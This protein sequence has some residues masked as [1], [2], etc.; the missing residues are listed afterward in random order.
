MELA[1]PSSTRLCVWGGAGTALLRLYGPP[2]NQGPSQAAGEG[3][4]QIRDGWGH[5]GGSQAGKAAISQHSVKRGAQRP[6]PPVTPLT[7]TTTMR[8]SKLPHPHLKAPHTPH[9][10]T[11]TAP[12][13]Q[14]RPRPKPTIPIHTHTRS[15]SPAAGGDV[16][17]GAAG[18]TC[19]ALRHLCDQAE[20]RGGACACAFR[21]CFR[22]VIVP[23]KR[24][25]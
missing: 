21:V 17:R 11:P 20:G 15:H 8:H 18:G 24:R 10:H 4:K 7:T 19:G 23:K 22:F 12:T 3:A 13:P 16:G 9:P 1:P 2:K 6:P 14:S 25:P 5:R